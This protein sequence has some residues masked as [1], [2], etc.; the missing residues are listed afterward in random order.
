MS[1]P[2]FYRF[3]N[4]TLQYAADSVY[5]P[6]FK[7]TAA[8]HSDYIYPVDSWFWFDSRADAESFWGINGQ[9]PAQWLQF[10]EALASSDQ[11]RNLLWATE[12]ANPILRD[13]LSV[14]LGQAAQMGSG[15]FLS[16]WGKAVAGS[17]VSQELATQIIELAEVCKLPPDFIAGLRA[18]A[19]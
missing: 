15:A 19:P 10:A 5:G 1:H 11:A 7:L 13:M 8:N 12:A 6:G 14:G 3:I 4:D 16:A 18:L 2:G 9:S 17:L